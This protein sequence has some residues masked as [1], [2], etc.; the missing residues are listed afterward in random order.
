MFIAF[1]LASFFARILTDFSYSLE[2]K[3][4]TANYFSEALCLPLSPPLRSYVLS[5]APSYSYREAI[6]FRC[7]EGHEQ[8][9][10][11]VEFSSICQINGTFLPDVSGV[12]CQSK[13]TS[14]PSSSFEL[15]VMSFMQEDVYTLR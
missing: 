4:D 15:F 2:P 3:I 1:G 9:G 11:Q 12:V 13:Q 14:Y 6:V 5:D 10:G 7:I 8:H